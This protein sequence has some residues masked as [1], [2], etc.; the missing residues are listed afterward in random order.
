[1]KVCQIMA[2]DEE[3][4]LENHFVDLSNGLLQLIDEVV[5]IG[6]EKYRHRF[7]EGVKFITLDLSKG[8]RNPLILLKLILILRRES[9]DIVH[10][11]ANKAVDIINRIK[12]FIPGLRIGT[13][14][15]R[16]K[17]LAMYAGMN[18]VIGVSK[19][20]VANLTHPDV[21]VVYNGV[22]PFTG[23]GYSKTDLANQFGLD[24]QQTI[25]LSIG[26]LFPVKAFDNLIKS[27]S[28][29]F[30]QLLIIGEGPEQEN[31]VKLIHDRG[32]T[33]HI[34]LTGY[35]TDVREMLA[36]ADLLVFASH[37]EGFSYVLVEALISKLPV[38]STRVPGAVEV[39]PDAFLV[40]VDNIEALSA[41]L[42]RTL[43]DLVSA[44]K[45]QQAL[46]DWSATTLTAETMVA[47]TLAIYQDVLNKAK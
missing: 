39:L 37:R 31:L 41:G 23:N 15:N 45:Q 40:D 43:T 3:G 21:R 9:A 26:R 14:H 2:G 34:T 44:R 33:K 30:G 36:A 42:A 6:H 35:R 17:S 10:A 11:Q 24:P 16:K 1:M 18:T 8:R 20:V 12:R 7:S 32:M 5:V 29:E 25:T 38:L 27:W 13:L 22:K 19:G 47:S 4:G 28:S 46:F